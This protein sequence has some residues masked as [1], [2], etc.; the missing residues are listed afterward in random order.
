MSEPRKVLT[1]HEMGA[2]DK[3]TIEAGIPGIILMENAA[4]R[5][6][7]FVARRFSPLSD[8]RIVIVCG[9]GNNGGDGLARTVTGFGCTIDDGGA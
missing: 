4:S 5:V 9:K 1:A 2:V 7:E 6:V 8:H 3:A